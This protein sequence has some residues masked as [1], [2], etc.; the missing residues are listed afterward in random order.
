MMDFSL[1]NYKKPSEV[2]EMPSWVKSASCK[3]L[4]VRCIYYFDLIKSKME[5]NAN[6]SLKERRIVLRRLAQDCMVDPS[7]L[8]SR[9]QPDLIKF[10]AQKNIELEQYWISKCAARGGSGRRLTKS[11]LVKQLAL[12]KSEFNI[13]ENLRIAE[14]FTSAIEKSLAKSKSELILLNE[15]LS[16][17]NKDLRERNKSLN[18]Q[19]R[20]III[21][22]NKMHKND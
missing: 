2:E 16:I 4:Y 3:K 20:D 22:L 14:A 10:I 11:E 9:R 19:L 5:M 21:A 13:L 15:E 8:S 18:G 1:D 17:E 12:L 7:L 6:L